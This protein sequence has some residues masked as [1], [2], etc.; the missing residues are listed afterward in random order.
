MHIFREKGRIRK[1]GD[2]DGRGKRMHGRFGS[3][4]GHNPTLRERNVRVIV[5]GVYGIYGR[6]GV[7][8]VDICVKVIGVSE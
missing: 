7:T 4:I 8:A 6:N 2:K 3:V 5:V 1:C